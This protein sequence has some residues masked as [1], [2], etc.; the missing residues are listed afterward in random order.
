MTMDVE[1]V[2]PGSGA[3][4]PDEIRTQLV[5]ECEAMVKYAL[6]AGLA[7]APATVVAVAAAK[8]GCGDE[9]LAGVVRAHAQLTR[10]VA[11]A[12]PGTIRLLERER[13]RHPMMRMLGPVV[14]IRQLM[15]FALVMLVAFVGL[16]TLTG[17]AR[18]TAVTDTLLA[19]AGWQPVSSALYLLAAAGLGAAF[20]A[21]FKANGYIATGTYDPTYDASYWILIVLGFIAGIVLALLIPIDSIGGQQELSKPLLALL[22]GFSAAAVH[23][24]LTRIIGGVEAIFRDAKEGAT[25]KEAELKSRAASEIAAVRADVA[26]RLVSIERVAAGDDGAA[27]A[28]SSLRQL[29]QELLPAG[30]LRHD[31]A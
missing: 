7:L 21:L 24:I 26:S 6:A 10:L 23:R 28:A 12:K 20:A 3:T 14:L 30:E 4:Y 18:Q 5:D 8:D 27:N 15:A 2:A 11:P 25:A 17:V 29:V 22:G 1:P 19:G 31:P 16:A 9:A 13:A